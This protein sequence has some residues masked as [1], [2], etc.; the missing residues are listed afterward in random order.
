MRVDRMATAPRRHQHAVVCPDV[1]PDASPV[2]CARA[3]KPGI[4][5][6]MRRSALAVL[7]TFLRHL[8]AAT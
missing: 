6:A 8:E 4:A 7:P 3:E 5:P 1:S 2:A